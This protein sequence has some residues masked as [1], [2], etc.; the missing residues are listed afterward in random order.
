MSYKFSFADN[1]IYSAN[2]VNNIR[3]NT[4]GQSTWKEIGDT[5]YW[6]VPDCEEGLYAVSFRARQNLQFGKTSFRTLRINGE[7]PYKEALFV[8]KPSGI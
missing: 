1:E 3:L 5:I 6:E 7:I 4:I 8:G 2:D